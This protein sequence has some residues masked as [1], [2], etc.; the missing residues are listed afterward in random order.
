MKDSKQSH[1]P[2][3]RFGQNFLRDTQVI[4]QIISA[5]H[6]RAGES[7]LEIGPG[8]GA[9]TLP[10]LKAVGTLQVVELDRDIIPTLK[11]SAQSQ[12]TLIVHE[13]DAMKFDFHACIEPGR[14]LHLVGN[15][16][17]NI[18]TPL[19]FHLFTQID[20]IADMHF[21]LQKEVV[22]RMVAGPGNKQYGRLSV[23][24][25]YYCAV[26]SLFDVAPESFYP[27]P[28]VNSSIV[29]LIPYETPP[30]IAT[31]KTFFDEMVREAFN[32]RRKTLRNSL[33]AYCDEAQFAQA[34]INP[35]LRAENLSVAD[36]VRLAN[37]RLTSHVPDHFIPT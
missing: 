11:A 6:P 25:Q 14:R 27:A 19:L 28:K 24:V 34:G 26:E 23:M 37:G 10:L 30:F 5:V 20:C 21:M 7:Y 13:A 1:A 8:L 35:D 18:S 2:R 32:Q 31:D 22:D 3:K 16:P 29:R 12:G 33:R 17:Y 4:H 36:F 15:L 9:L